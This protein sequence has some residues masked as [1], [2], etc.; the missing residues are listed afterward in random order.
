MVVEVAVHPPT[1]RA[2]RIW[3]AAAGR[4]TDRPRLEGGN[5]LTASTLLPESSIASR[6]RRFAGRSALFGDG[7]HEAHPVAL[8]GVDGPAQTLS[9]ERLRAAKVPHSECDDADL[10]MHVVFLPRIRST[11]EAV[12]SGPGD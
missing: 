10:R 6:M 3:S 4:M 8:L 1:T 12:P 2:M 5:I 9:V 11:V 7:E